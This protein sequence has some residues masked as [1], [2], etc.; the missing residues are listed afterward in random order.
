M[1]NSR[2]ATALPFGPARMRPVFEWTRPATHVLLRVVAALLF[3]QH[4]AQKL[5]G[6]LGGVD[7]SGAT[8]PLLSLLGL[9]GVLELFGGALILVG[10]LVRPVAL[11]LAGEMVAAYIMAHLPRGGFPV[12]NQGELAL[13]YA[14]LFVFLLGNGAGGWSLDQWIGERRARREERAMPPAERT[15]RTPEQSRRARH[16]AA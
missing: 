10:L 11:L 4:G 16:T 3:M 5:L 6:V 9:A 13:V 7:G 2:P 14:A 1:A 12:Q 15:A 8:V